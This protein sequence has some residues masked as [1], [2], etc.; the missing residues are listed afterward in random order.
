M[1]RKFDCF[2]NCNYYCNFISNWYK[3]YKCYENA[4]KSYNTL[5]RRKNAEKRELLLSKICRASALA[6]QTKRE[7]ESHFLAHM[8]LLRKAHINVVA[9]VL[10]SNFLQLKTQLW[11]INKGTI[12]EF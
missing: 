2:I 6:V 8:G 10:F 1:A 3:A 9:G 11:L 4:K 12:T 7:K 5:P